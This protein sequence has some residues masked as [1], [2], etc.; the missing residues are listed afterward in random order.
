MEAAIHTLDLLGEAKVLLYFDLVFESAILLLQELDLVPYVTLINKA[1]VDLGV[2]SLR[3]TNI[4]LAEVLILTVGTDGALLRRSM[5]VLFDST[6]G[7]LAPAPVFLC[8]SSLA[9]GIAH[10]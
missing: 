9:A 3:S 6:S 4:H 8:V 5:L 1:L 2:L 7:W 10:V